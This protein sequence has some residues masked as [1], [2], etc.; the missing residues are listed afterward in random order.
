MSDAMSSPAVLA[1]ALCLVAHLLA[2]FPF[3]SDRVAHLK[4][5]SAAALAEHGAWIFGLFYLA[6]LPFLGPI[7]ALLFA[8]SQAL[9]HVLIDQVKTM[10]MARARPTGPGDWSARPAL[11][12]LIDQ[13]AHLGVLAVSF[14]L[15]GSL[16]PS[17][18]SGSAWL[19]QTAESWLGLPARTGTSTLL[20]IALGGILLLVNAWLGRYMID[21]LINPAGA[22]AHRGEPA[23]GAAIGVVERLL[24]VGLVLIGHWEGIAMVLGIKVLARFPRLAGD[25]DHRFA[26]QF[27]LGTMASLALALASAMAVRALILGTV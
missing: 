20:L 8:A 4:G 1:V 9:S 2:D 17:W 7:G 14:R 16:D 15:L 12:A 22:A 6:M 21:E 19:G 18:N 25:E 24:I 27:I 11:T 13:M 5:V 10:L 26:D 23:H 3:Q